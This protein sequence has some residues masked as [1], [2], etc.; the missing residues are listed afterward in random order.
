MPRLPT[1][2]HVLRGTHGPAPSRHAF[3]Y[4]TL[5]RSGRPF[6]R[7]SGSAA[8]CHSAGA[9]AAPPTP[10]VQPPR[11]IGRQ[12]TERRRFGLRAFRSPLLRAYSLFLGVLRCF[13]SPGCRPGPYAFRPGR[14]GITRHGLPHSGI[15]GSSRASRSPRRFAA[16][17]RP[18]SA[19]QAKASTACPSTLSSLSRRAHPRPRRARA[20]PHL[21][22]ALTISMQRAPGRLPTDRARHSLV[23]VPGYLAPQPR[24]RVV[25]RGTA[26]LHAGSRRRAT[27]PC[28][29]SP[30]PGEGRGSP[31]YWGRGPARSERPRAR[32][33]MA[34]ADPRALPRKEVIQPQLPLRLPCYDFVPVTSPTLDSCLPQRG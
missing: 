6:Q 26:P 19:L 2:F 11:R 33:G 10:A 23:N 20:G 18:S 30:R 5:T 22:G 13:S 8:V 27:P 34:R 21:V 29:P 24:W 17:P 15:L 1:E 25:V 4:G 9:A 31:G 7:R 14:A 3:P 32:P 28:S 16:W 12:A